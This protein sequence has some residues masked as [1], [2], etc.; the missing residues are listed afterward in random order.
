MDGTGRDMYID[1]GRL[2]QNMGAPIGR[3][4]RH[5]D[6]IR[7]ETTYGTWFMK[8]VRR[9]DQ[10]LW[11]QRMDPILRACGFE[12]MPDFFVW[13]SKWIVMRYIPGRVARYRSKR[14]LIQAAGLL[15]KFHVASRAYSKAV[16][17][18]S[19]NP[20]PERLNRRVGQFSNLMAS[21]HHKRATC[22]EQTVPVSL[23]LSVGDTYLRWG[24]RAIVRLN[25][26]G[27]SASTNQDVTRQAVAHRDLASHNI[28]I[29]N[30]N[31]PWLID[32]ET[33]AFDLQLGDLWQ[34]ASRALVEWHWDTAIYHHILVSYER[35]RP[36][37]K[38][39]KELL[40]HLFLFPNDFYRETLG[41]YKKRRGFVKTHVWSLLQQMVRDQRRWQSFLQEIG[42][43]W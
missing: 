8:P 37:E 17:R 43:A 13:D 31:R 35:V 20:L 19:V 39:E 4:A 38:K 24:E 11:W 7:F 41:L 23:L 9:L 21:I 6:F 1:W 2:Q 5:R 34:M 14:D 12:A 28:V 27:L 36:L 40:H 42:V 29:D 3:I 22:S 25:E 18:F 15:A 10:T 32:F 26:L 16:P 30:L 33:A